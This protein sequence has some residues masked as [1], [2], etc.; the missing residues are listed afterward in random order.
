MKSSR[1]SSN[2]VFMLLMY[3]MS[4]R[5]SAGSSLMSTGGREVFNVMM[6]GATGD[7]RTDDGEVSYRLIT[8]NHIWS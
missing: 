1:K 6:E 8:L 2:V 7:G 3:C 5:A 4:C